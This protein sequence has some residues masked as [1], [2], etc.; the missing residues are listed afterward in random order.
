MDAKIAQRLCH[1]LASCEEAT[2]QRAL[3]SLGKL[4]AQAT[5]KVDELLLLK[6]CKALYYMLWMTD[7]PLKVRR[8]AVAIVETQSRFTDRANR[9]HFF[10]CLFRSMSMEW[11]L[12]DKHRLDKML[13]FVRVVVAS[14]LEV[15]NGG[16]WEQG[17]MREF[18]RI[19]LDKQG[20]F[21]KR[22]LGLAFQ[23]I[24]VFWEE[25]RQNR[26]GL[27][28]SG[29]FTELSREVFLR[30]TAPFLQLMVTLDN[31]QVLNTLEM[32]VLKPAPGVPGMPVQ[33]YVLACERLAESPAI[34]GSAR[35]VFKQI[36]QG[37]EG[38]VDADQDLHKLVD[39]TVAAI[40]AAVAELR[41]ADAMGVA[42]ATHAHGNAA[43][44][45][46][47]ASAER[48]ANR[49]K[50]SGAVSGIAADG[51]AEDGD[52]EM[53]PELEDVSAELQR[54]GADGRMELDPGEG[55]VSLAEAFLP[56][57]SKKG[58]GKHMREIA[59]L[60]RVRKFMVASGL[61]DHEMLKKLNSPKV[62]R[63][64]A[65][66]GLHAIRSLNPDRKFK[67]ARKL[68]RIVN[69]TETAQAL[70]SRR[71]SVDVAKALH[72]IKHTA[73]EKSIVRKRNRV[74]TETKRVVFNLKN[75]QV[76]TIPKKTKS[77]LT[78]PMWY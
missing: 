12:L 21:N 50:E 68:H 57:T 33:G 37:H 78:M 77:T 55:F 69:I 27:L 60:D 13:L 54:H 6:I 65:L 11:P 34:R 19:V 56:R 28:K 31:K 1:M 36:P 17:D 26:E 24:Q 38:A 29:E 59:T 43:A 49:S 44:T 20:I 64:M 47:G 18:A 53:V 62:R 63:Q 67:C 32:Y 40:E 8:V 76:A 7:K 5:E 39:E 41:Q 16:G 75:N 70:P 48:S 14:L 30:L 15:L 72:N 9:M 4:F 45:N 51:S 42:V 74:S 46:A 35:K 61:D 2:R 3:R 66:L 10:S 58:L 22:S 25:F 23:F 52:V 73:P 71:R